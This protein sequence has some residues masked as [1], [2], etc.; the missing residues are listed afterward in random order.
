MH[1]QATLGEGIRRWDSSRVGVSQLRERQRMRWRWWLLKYGRE[2]RRWGRWNITARIAV[3]CR[4]IH[5]PKDCG[6]AS[7]AQYPKPC[8]ACVIWGIYF[9]KML[10]GQ[11]LFCGCDIEREILVHLISRK[12]AFWHPE[13]SACSHQFVLLG[14]MRMVL[15]RS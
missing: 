13:V 7:V 9:P 1:M 4:K 3:V 6:A 10:P 5:F 8:K 2:G 15:Q 14:R 11:L 12:L